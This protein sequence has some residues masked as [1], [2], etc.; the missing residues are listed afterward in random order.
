MTT[1]QTILVAT[2]LLG[3]SPIWSQASD[4][5]PAFS[6][7][8]LPQGQVGVAYATQ[9]ITGAVSGSSTPFTF[10]ISAGALPPG[11][12]LNPQN[13]II[14][15][16]PSLSGTFSFTVRV[17]DVLGRSATAPAQFVITNPA[18]LPQ[19]TT[20]ALPV[21]VVGQPYPTTTITASGGTGTGFTFVMLPLSGI[22]FAQPPPG[23]TLNG[24]GVLSGT[25]FGGGNFPVRIQV[26]DSGSSVGSRDYNIQITTFDCPQAYANL[27]EAYSSAFV[28]SPFAATSFAITAGQ[29]PSGLSLNSVSGLLSGI[30]NAAGTFTF[31]VQATDSLSRQVSKSCS[32]T[33][34]NSL[35]TT[36][37]RT[38]AR[39]GV[40][41][42]SFIS[43]I[44][45]QS[46]YSHSITNGALPDG[47]TL[48][49]ASGR[50]SGTPTQP[51]SSLARV[52]TL[53]S[54]GTAT[55]LDLT[56]YVQ[57]RDF[58]PILRCP[59]PGLA[60][61]QLY[62]SGLSLNSNSIVTYSISGSLPP[63]LS[64][65]SS[66]GQISG[67]AINAGIYAFTALASASS[68]PPLT[69][70]CTIAVTDSNSP[71]LSV[72]CPDQN[73]MLVGEFY[74][75]PAIASGGRRPYFFSMYQS[76][77]PSGL[78]LNP[79]TG[80]VSGTLGAL[81]P[82]FIFL[83]AAEAAVGGPRF[84]TQEFLYAIR[85]TDASGSSTIT[86]PLCTNTVSDTPI[87][88]ILTT[89]IPNG[90]LASTYSAA[91][92][93]AGGIPPYSA[94]VTG[95]FP[96]G[97]SISVAGSQV[98]I[99]GSPQQSGSFTFSLSVL[100]GTG[101]RVSRTYSLTISGIDPLRFTSA[102]QN[103]ATVGLN[104]AGSFSA[105]GGAPPYRFA[106]SG[107]SLPP[108]LSLSSDGVLR[109]L[110]TTA[111]TSR[112][113]VELSD[114][115]GGR[116]N[117]SFSVV[118]FQGSFRLGCPNLQAELG[119]PYSSLANVL[120]GSQPFSFY[121]AA[122]QLPA[123]LI[124][125]PA[126]GSITGRPSTAGAFVFTFGVRDARQAQTQAQ[127]S[128][129]VLN[130]PLRVITEG[131]IP[132]RAAQ[133]YAG[134][135]E[136]AGGQGGPYQWSLLSAAP[137]AGFTVAANGSFS[138]TA[139]KKGSFAATVQVRDLAGVSATR[140][141]SI[142]ASDST[143]A[144][145]CPDP[146]SFQLGVNSSGRFALSG[147]LAPY[148][149]SLLSGTLPPGFELIS[150]GSFNMLGIEAGSFP[151]QVQA[152]DDTNTAVTARCVFQVTG[153]PFSITTDA[154][155]NGRVAIAYSAGL[156]SRGGVGAVRYSLSRGGL[157]AGLEFDSSNGSIGGIPEQ[158]GTFS[159]GLSATDS[160]QRRAGKT[161]SLTI[162]P[163]PLPLRIST[164]SP[165][166][167]G[168]VGR[169]YTTGFAAE[170]GKAPYA[171][172]I[173]GSVPGLAAT[174]DTI[175]GTPSLAGQFSIG[176][177]V[178]DATGASASKTFA[179]RIKA[180][181]LII[182]TDSLPDG[183]EGEPYAIG[184]V[185]EGGRA[186]FSWSIV[187]G[188]IPPGVEFNSS[189]GNFEG[190]PTQSGAFSVAVEVTDSTGATSRR[191]FSFEVRP[192]GV[193]RLSITTAALANG[194]A[195][196]A[197]SASVGAL[198]GRL[199]YSW[200]ISGD[201]PAG[202]SFSSDGTISG[203]PQTVG[204]SNFLVSVSDS[205]GLRA[206]R[207]FSLTI[208]TASVPALSIESLPDTAAANQTLPLTL[209]MASAFG[210]AVSGRLTLSFVPD[211][212]HGADDPSIRFSGGSRTLDFSIPAGS[213]S[214]TLAGNASISTGT[215]A[216]TIRIDSLL[217]FAG[218][219][220]AGPTRSIL[221]TRA[222]PVITTLTLIR[223]TGGLEI[224]IEGATNTRQLG[225]ARVTFTAS[226]SVDLTTASQIA[227]NV[228]SA[229][230]NWF[231]SSAS[232][233]FGGRF[234]L[235]LPFNVSGEAGGI[236]GVS[237]VIT[238]GEGSSSAANA[239]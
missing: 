176:V 199:P 35:Q 108:G 46:G 186:P 31:T 143:L 99:S 235:T 21:G 183:V 134:Q 174:S 9:V 225:E 122:G 48:E 233:P 128:I 132:T 37:A 51:G 127:C 94:N 72:A 17:A 87:L 88:R 163:G 85:V 65:N 232:L 56:I 228:S 158:A 24:A 208:G 209:R 18:N 69:A 115:A 100:D 104:Y 215:L 135:L 53:D 190:R 200:A 32:I 28:L 86:S 231:A 156:S 110:P 180:D 83:D 203:T 36:S 20:N 98:V 151:A 34:Q 81:P 168:F 113:D 121:L 238:N 61:G 171:F 150:S 221:M 55:D 60:S 136:A 40:P 70:S 144:L 44:G 123:G 90:T 118:V 45:G 89:Q 207:L 26:T 195:G 227:V 124:L 84:A 114:G 140:Q 57:A 149:V 103:I 75:S 137:E 196:L 16:I 58:Q 166:S 15:G 80:L 30:A 66:T 1:M 146:S 126:T 6:T 10:S 59:L 234:S 49:A 201:L 217:N 101:Q 181:G 148:R 153:E 178:T 2:L 237:V 27:G 79:S 13:A 47:L 205:L 4:F 164:A 210:V 189:N 125:D 162:E 119:V 52:R 173:T 33:P 179:L 202:L 7:F 29:L 204:T 170:G 130:G 11:L 63:G 198:G 93:V 169:S 226:G 38:T 112:F 191:S 25:P 197:Y 154:L 54:L 147:G 138:G 172:S 73:D 14:Q 62:N 105:A 141:I 218:M 91:I 165:L 107:G 82:S 160:A 188:A 167:D 157:P 39:V 64:L 76:S 43:A 12:T 74:A 139:T 213:T 117:G 155:A 224:R 111:G 106:L 239:N 192:P 50:I 220:I 109:G 194:N 19:V 71:P 229:I 175:A 206:S 145:A 22:S 222:A 8:T 187:S 97:L 131:P 214:V 5:P 212:I 68:G 185:R 216:G 133:P 77:L 129:G 92:Q 67:N 78:T 23:L 184:V 193:D 42:R 95:A 3:T 223:S 236:S 161:L 219:S 96:P 159:L 177:S 230:Q 152:V 102:A 120:G 41:Y 211:S 116:V 142:A 182:L